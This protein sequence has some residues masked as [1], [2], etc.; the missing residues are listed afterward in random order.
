[1]IAEVCEGRF[2][3]AYHYGHPHAFVSTIYAGEAATCR[4]LHDPHGFVADC[5]AR[6]TPYPAAL[7]A[8]AALKTRI[9]AA[10]DLS[11][12]PARLKASLAALGALVDDAAALA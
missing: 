2:E 10:F 7:R 4:A 5:K 11:A 12:D 9:E 6:L 3:C 1:M 8:P